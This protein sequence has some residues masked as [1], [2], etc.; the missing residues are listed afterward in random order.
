MDIELR[1]KGKSVVDHSKDGQRREGVVRQA[2]K[3]KR[4]FQV[5]ALKRCPKRKGAFAVELFAGKGTSPVAT[6][7]GLRHLAIEISPTLAKAYKRRNPK[8]TV[9]ATS[10][11]K[12]LKSHHEE[13]KKADVAL[14]E[15]DPFGHP[16]TALK[17]FLKVNRPNKPMLALV[18]YG[19]LF[20]QVNSKKGEFTR[21]TAWNRLKAEVRKAA[22]GAGCSVQALGWSV[23]ERV[24]VRTTS[25]VIYG[26]FSIKSLSNKDSHLSKLKSGDKP[27]R[28]V[29][30]VED[31]WDWI[32]LLI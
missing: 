30:K 9:L 12:A 4:E 10:W 19:Y 27:M 31:V 28:D 3:A 18:T 1:E 32:D 17:A 20:E 2:F 8:A 21:E 7:K 15:V 16:F 24:G 5:E 29:A 22:R 14:L 11:K 25:K 6:V 23:P 26:A 13:I